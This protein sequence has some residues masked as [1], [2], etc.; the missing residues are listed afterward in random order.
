MAARSQGHRGRRVTP[1][2]LP[3]GVM[4]PGLRH[5]LALS[6]Q[7]AAPVAQGLTS[8]LSGWQPALAAPDPDGPATRIDTTPGG[9]RILS[10][11]LDAPMTGLPLASVLC[12]AIADIAQAWAA[13][14]P[15]GLALHAAAVEGGAGLVVLAGPH[16]AGKSTL[17]TGLAL[18]PGWTLW[19]DDVLPLR[20]DGQAVAL[21]IRPRLRLPLPQAAGPAMRALAADASLPRDDRYAYVA[22]PRQAPHGAAMP[23][24]VLIRLDRRP[25]TPAC[26]H[27]LPGAEALRLLEGQAIGGDDRTLPRLIR[28]AARLVTLR[29]VFDDPDEAVRLLAEALASPAALTALR[30]APALPDAPPT[31]A[32][33]LPPRAMGR[34]WQRVPGLV[35]RRLG[36]GLALW[37]PDLAGGLALN[38][39]GAALWRMLADPASGC[40]LADAL[41]TAFPDEPP[42]RIVADVALALGSLL[43]AGALRPASA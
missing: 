28:L 9:F 23:P 6:P 18:E 39:T 35:A 31:E 30:P 43:A 2:A 36:G 33:P 42:A 14:R 13:E 41:C 5:R 29:L 25:G 21:G 4:L 22:P 37:S 24:R 20:R 19:G 7:A 26:L 10:D 34:R 3:H 11:Y 1:A 17:A 40:D 32:A 8:L 16:R 12:A 38:P 15:G 27:A